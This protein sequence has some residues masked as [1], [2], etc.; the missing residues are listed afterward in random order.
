[1]DDTG[2]TSGV[3]KI[4]SPRGGQHHMAAN[5]LMCAAVAAFVLI[6]GVNTRQPEAVQHQAAVSC[7]GEACVLNTPWT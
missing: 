4:T 2:S 7:T 5:N 3:V 6:F 1:M